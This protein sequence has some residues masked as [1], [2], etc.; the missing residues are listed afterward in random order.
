MNK[1]LSEIKKNKYTTLAI[2]GFILLLVLGIVLYN[3]LFPNA[4]S[5]VYGNRLDGIDEVMVTEKDFDKIEEKLKN[6]KNIEEIKGYLSGRS[7]KFIV[8]VKEGTKAE[9]AKK[10]PNLIVEDFSKEQKTYFD[11]EVFILSSIEEEKG[12][13]IIGYMNR[14]NTEFSFSSA[15]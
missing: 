5:P 15:S 4:G 1:I 12:Y 2:V 3:F 9:D 6:E 8:T 13:P 7:I 10:I 14:S 11:Y